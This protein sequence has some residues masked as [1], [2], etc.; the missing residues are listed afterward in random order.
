MSEHN[1]VGRRKKPH[2]NEMWWNIAFQDLM[3]DE[4]R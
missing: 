2:A 3:S 1:S 4:M